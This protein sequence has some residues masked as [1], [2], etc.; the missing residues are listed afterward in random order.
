MKAWIKHKNEAGFWFTFLL[1]IYVSV[2]QNSFVMGGLIVLLLVQ[3]RLQY[4]S[5]VFSDQRKTRVV[6]AVLKAISK[7]L[8]RSYMIS[9]LKVVRVTRLWGRGETCI[10][11]W[12][13]NG[14][15]TFG[16]I[17]HTFMTY[18][19]KKALNFLSNQL[20]TVGDRTKA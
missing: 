16:R 15:F 12:E 19:S 14:I 9:D 18:S 10:L 5:F 13:H 20:D 8:P 2:T 7:T 17:S 3:F 11:I 6:Q 1:T 4:I